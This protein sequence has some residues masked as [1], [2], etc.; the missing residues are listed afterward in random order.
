MRLSFLSAAFALIS[1]TY[2][3]TI[4]DVDG[5]KQLKSDYAPGRYIVQYET[6]A[7]PE[8]QLS[9]IS[10]LGYDVSVQQNY[11]TNIFH[12]MS[13]EVL[14]DNSTT[15]EDLRSL[16]N[17]KSV[18]RASIVTLEFDPLTATAPKWNPHAVTG[19]DK[20]HDLG[21]T[22]KDVVIGVVDTGVNY[23]HPA[24]GGG[25][26]EG[27]TV[28]GGWDFMEDPNNPK[29]DPMDCAGHGTFVSSVIVANTATMLGVAPNAKI[30]MYKVFGCSSST[31]DDYILA[32]LLKAY[33]EKPNVISLSLGSD[34]GYNS[35]PLSLVA[36]TISETIPIVYAAG[37]SGQVGV[38]RAS[39]GAS[40][41]GAIAVAA[42]EAKELVAWPAKITSSGGETLDFTYVSQ[43][44]AVFPLD[45]TFD[46]DYQPNA[47]FVRSDPSHTGKFLMAPKGSCISN[48]LLNN[49]IGAGY[50][51]A[52]LFTSD[53]R[54]LRLDILP[55][56]TFQY[57][58]ATDTDVGAWVAAQIKAGNTLKVTF[59]SSA[60]IETKEK[61]YLEAGQINYYTSWGPTF[62]NNFYPTVAAPGGDVIG[63]DSD[64][65]YYVASGTSFATPYI[66]G[67]LALY[68]G[69]FPGTD[70]QV[71][72]NKVIAATNLL[73]K[74]VFGNV[75]SDDTST[76]DHSQFA[77]LIQQGAGQIDAVRLF[78]GKT[79]VISSP[80]LEL[81][82]TQYRVSEHTIT[83]INEGD[84]LVTY[85]ITHSGMNAVALRTSSNLYPN[86]Y[87]PPSLNA[88]PVA[89]IS[90]DSITLGPGESGSFTVDIKAPDGIDNGVAPLLQGYFTISG[91]NGDG[92]RVPY[93]GV[94]AK[95][96]D[97]TPWINMSSYSSETVPGTELPV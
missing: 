35:A 20:L 91:S 30:R 28:I 17:I 66:S 94:E 18:W 67:V 48:F 40:A 97:W 49:M 84:S 26:G 77:P 63:A 73:D 85:D 51:G 5:A 46:V 21:Y 92:L 65:G 70:P 25:L 57:A 81:N 41:K 64:G 54:Y 32:G 52:V 45:K 1:T 14:N 60:E 3:F 69:A 75:N 58:A 10:A 62:E 76:I 79:R 4:D 95:T 37:N 27:F 39:P 59:D 72:R 53:I 44:G 11:E 31:T 86:V 87:Y 38:M 43:N 71:L 24:V 15:L 93:I 19:V 13:F 56:Y 61:K 90:T 82:D 47:C 12:G 83:F 50:T 29:P 36:D 34:S 6:P 8:V 78:E 9:R 74:Y 80:Y 2:G 22:G 55:S 42:T 96:N 68:L 33:S 16:E 89:T 7:S 88:Q 23:N